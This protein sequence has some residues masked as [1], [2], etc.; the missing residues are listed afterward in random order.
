MALKHAAL[1]DPTGITLTGCLLHEK[2]TS[3]EDVNF[4][5]MDNDGSFEDGKSIRKKTSFA[6]SGQGLSTIS[7]P[8]VG[9]GAATSL[10]P[11]IDSS[12][13]TEKAEGAAD[14]SV[15]AHYYAA[16]GGDFAA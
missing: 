10:L 1:T 11:H 15:A 7:L 13:L 4:E 14:F 5:A 8:T 6:L 16:G 2:R 12:E 9:G 3:I